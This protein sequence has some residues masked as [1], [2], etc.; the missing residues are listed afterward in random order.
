MLWEQPSELPRFGV[1]TEMLLTHQPSP[2]ASP[3]LLSLGDRGVF[4]LQ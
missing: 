4:I 1:S 2:T 3:S